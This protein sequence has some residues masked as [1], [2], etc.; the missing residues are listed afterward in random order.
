M[1]LRA[2]PSLTILILL[3]S[4]EGSDLTGS[5]R[6][7]A[8]GA[9]CSRDHITDSLRGLAPCRPRDKVI[10]VPWPNNTDIHQ[11][12]PSHVVVRRCSGG[13]HGSS[14]CVAVMTR[15]RQVS[16]MMGKCP[17]GGGKCDKECAILEVEDEEECEC[18]CAKHL[19]EECQAK[20]E[21]HSWRGESCECQCKD[22]EARR[23]CLDSPS[24]L[25][26]SS[27]CS[28]LCNTLSS[29]PTGLTHDPAT[30]SCQPA[31]ANLQAPAVGE[32][33]EDRD[34]TL[35]LPHWTETV[36]ILVLASLVVILAIF[37][38]A[39]LRRI[40]NLK[41]KLKDTR[42]SHVSASP[43]LYSP[44]PISVQQSLSEG[45]LQTPII[46]PLVHQPQRPNNKMYDLYSSSSSEV[47]SERQTDLSYYTDTSLTVTPPPC[48]CNTS[49]CSTLLGRET[50]V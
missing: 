35:L 5:P 46:K 14:S 37:S 4:V 43:N 9:A 45:V 24:R 12:S 23:R 32:P 42:S 3:K 16:V 44:C 2:L 39:L 1:W 19:E 28:C 48:N 49:E 20:K 29:C 34:T 22:Q 17:V 36:V 18:G 7:L 11:L 13:C 47:S 30:C 41:T 33:R 40:H 6:Y 25:W 8:G 26:S 50:N 10:P 27:S 31:R 38:G 15:V 21:T